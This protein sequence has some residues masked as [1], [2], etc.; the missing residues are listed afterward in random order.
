LKNIVVFASGSGSNFQSIIDSISSGS[1][2]ATI[3]G[4]I[5]DRENIQSLDRAKFHN[6]PYSILSPNNFDNPQ[7]YETK[8]FDVLNSYKADII[9]LAG[10]LKKIPNLI[11]KSYQNRIL[12]IHPSLLPKY[13]GKGFYGKKVHEAVLN[14]GETVSGCTVHIVNEIYDDGPIL[15]QTEVPVFDHDSTIDLARR[16]LAEEHKLYPKVISEFLKTLF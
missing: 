5:T 9:I 1:L 15:G 7:Q 16:V 12:N 13:G 14:N 4:L 2:E 6:I 11:I 10:Y 3:T 8:L